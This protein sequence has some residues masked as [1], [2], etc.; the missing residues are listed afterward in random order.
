MAPIEANVKM[1]DLNKKASNPILEVLC[2]LTIKGYFYRPATGVLKS[3]AWLFLLSLCVSV[4]FPINSLAA[5]VEV[6]VFHSQDKYPA[7]GTF[8]VLF[9]LHIADAWYIHGTK[10]S[11]EDLVATV[12]SFPETPG[13][14]IKDIRFPSP[15][16]KKFDYSDEA[17]ELFSGTILARASLEV[18]KEAALGKSTLNGT[19]SFQACS[20]RN[21]MPPERVQIPL[22]VHIAPA[23]A[24]VE[25]LNQKMFAEQK[26]MAFKALMPIGTGFW[27]TLLGIFLG[28]M[29][30]N[31]TPC[32]YP[33]IPITVS[34]FGGKSSEIQGRTF[35]HGSCMWPVSP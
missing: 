20:S 19:L 33:L 16:K 15:E 4:L 10:E 23:H 14:Y 3:W 26:G 1:L 24:S 7:G 27:L 17:I 5:T 12:L 34:Y 25:R 18:G 6:K 8:P 28:G 31:L 29:A 9:Q 13:I 2:R 21:C 35:V 11:G 22:E 30:L 32:I